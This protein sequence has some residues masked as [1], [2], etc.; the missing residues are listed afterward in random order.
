MMAEE[1]ELVVQD[2]SSVVTSH[3]RE[4][5]FHGPVTP[6]SVLKLQT[7]LLEAAAAPSRDPVV[8][9]YINSEGGDLY[10]GLAAMDYIATFRAPVH[11]VVQGLVAS[12]ATLIAL[13]GKRRFIMPHAHLLVHQLSTGFW[14]KFNEMVEE[15]KTSKQLMKLL[16][17]IYVDRTSMDREDVKAMLGKETHLSAKKAIQLGFA[18]EVYRA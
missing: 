12:A 18:D 17:R 13:A 11:T 4:V 2:E 6:A 9:L 8:Y 5:F 15:Y 14:G 16:T 10:A 3:G 7:T 1:T